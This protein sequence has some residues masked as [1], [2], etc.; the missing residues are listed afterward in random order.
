MFGY[1]RYD[2]PNLYLKDLMLYKA[3]Y[4]GLC[5]SIGASCGQMARVGLTYDVTFLSALL[6]NMT[7]TNITVE[8]QNCFEH[9]LKKRP[10][11]KV[12]ELTKELG[13]LNTVLV[14]YKLTDDISDGG[15][16]RGRRIWFKKGFRRAKKT[17]PALVEIVERYMKE[18]S[19]TEKEKTASPDAAAEPSASMMRDISDHF[20][21]DRASEATR[22]LFYGLGKWVYLIDALDDYGKDFKKKNYNP[23]VLTYNSPNKAELME[24]HGGEIGFLFDTLFYSMRESLAKIPFSFNRDLTDNVILRGLPLETA[25]VMKGELPKKMQV[26]I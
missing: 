8:K 17:Y 11:A 5:K 12:D 9:R 2:L 7:G 4:C 13:A 22:E 26:K 14:Y 10:I 21:K 19:L 23:F 1:V 18:Q 16:G 15:K 25:R 20:L 24:M 6:H 3:L